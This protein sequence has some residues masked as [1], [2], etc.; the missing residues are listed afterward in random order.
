MV[1]EL[2]DRLVTGVLSGFGVSEDLLRGVRPQA[3]ANDSPRSLRTTRSQHYQDESM[4]HEF[5]MAGQISL[6]MY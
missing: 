4:L 2:E 5:T 3:I 6:E 1:S